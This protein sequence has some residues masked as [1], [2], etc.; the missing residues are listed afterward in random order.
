[1]VQHRDER[2]TNA[3]FRVE[4]SL[5]RSVVD[6]LYYGQPSI[7]FRR[8]FKALKLKLDEGKKHE[9]IA[10]LYGEESITFNVKSKSKDK[11]KGKG[12]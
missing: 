1:M 7:L 2:E 9:I 4:N 5:Y 11:N 6:R 10:F 8:F 12:K 3:A